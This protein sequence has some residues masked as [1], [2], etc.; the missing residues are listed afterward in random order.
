MMSKDCYHRF[1]RWILR[2]QTWREWATEIAQF[3]TVGLGAYI[4]NV[5]LFNLLAYSN[6]LHLPG[7]KSLT[8]KTISVTAS[9][10]FA[11]VA[12]RLWT[13]REQ[14]SSYKLREF[15]QFVAVNACGLLI[16]LGCLVFSR[17][18]LE[19]RTQLADNISSNIIGLIIGT[20][21]RYV[22][23]RYVIFR[24]VS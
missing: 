11:W 4:V 18:V 19:M 20:G 1:T 2:G 7:D 16:E 23:Y 15:L 8:A 14:R 22:M 21:F 17:Y 9:V 5:G 10:I 12:N 13:F 6:V 24:K 3:C